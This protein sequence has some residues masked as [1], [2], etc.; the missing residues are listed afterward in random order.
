MLSFGECQLFQYRTLWAGWFSL[1][2]KDYQRGPFPFLKRNVKE[3]RCPHSFSLEKEYAR[4]LL[5][6]GCG[7][8]VRGRKV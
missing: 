4:R 1:E 7:F 3:V 8:I 2:F 6:S 5:R